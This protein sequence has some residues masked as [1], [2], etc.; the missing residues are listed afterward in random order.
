MQHITYSKWKYNT[1]IGLKPLC[2]KCY[3][4]TISGLGKMLI[5][6]MRSLQY[7][8]LKQTLYKHP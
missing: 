2:A 3:F 1:L 6:Y 8:K 4:S 5:P 7:M